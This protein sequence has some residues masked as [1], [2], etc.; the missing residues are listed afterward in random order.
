MAGEAGIGEDGSDIAIEFDGRW[1]FAGRGCQD[2]CKRDRHE[3]EE[4]KEHGVAGKHGAAGKGRAAGKH[5]APGKHGAAG[6][7][8]VRE[9]HDPVLGVGRSLASAGLMPDWR[10]F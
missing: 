10:L 7:G 2:R 9:N 3:T 5:W 8:R 6:M 4:R 1:W